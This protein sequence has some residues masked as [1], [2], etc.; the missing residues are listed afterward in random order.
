MLSVSQLRGGGGPGIRRRRLGPLVLAPIRGTGGGGGGRS[1]TALKEGGIEA[2][3][4]GW[5]FRDSFLI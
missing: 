4:E 5:G 3:L 2:A 1:S